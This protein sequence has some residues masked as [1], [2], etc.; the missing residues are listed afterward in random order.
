MKNEL[1]DK[2]QK[3]VYPGFYV[4][5]CEACQCVT[6]ICPE[7]GNNCCNGFEECGTCPAAQFQQKKYG[8]K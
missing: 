6:V 8:E 2:A 4:Q 7:C 3:L 1:V 5:W